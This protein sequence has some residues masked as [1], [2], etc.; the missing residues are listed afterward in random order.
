[1]TSSTAVRYRLASDCGLCGSAH[2]SHD[3]GLSES[4]VRSSGPIGRSEPCLPEFLWLRNG[5]ELMRLSR[6]FLPFVSRSS[7]GLLGSFLGPSGTFCQ[8]VFSQQHD[9]LSPYGSAV[10]SAKSK[11]TRW[12]ETDRTHSSVSTLSQSFTVEE[13]AVK[14]PPNSG[15]LFPF[16]PQHERIARGLWEPPG[17]PAAP[18]LFGYFQG[19]ADPPGTVPLTRQRPAR[20]AR[21]AGGL[22]E[23][24]DFER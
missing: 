19:R 20:T 13:A 22:T 18:C 11:A 14:R 6:A 2:L 8:P 12:L 9:I 16:S 1:M 21:D 15:E 23:E 5:M 24:M 4:S 3:A 10:V 7:G 17:P